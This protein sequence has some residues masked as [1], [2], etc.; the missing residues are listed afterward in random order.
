ME[1]AIVQELAKY[2]QFDQVIAIDGSEISLANCLKN[3][4]NP[5]VIGQVA[6]LGEYQT[7]VEILSDA[8]LA[9]ACLPHSLSLQTVKAAIE[10]KCHLVDLVGSQYEEKL[11]LHEEAKSAGVAIVPGCGVAPGIV[12]FLAA[13]GVELLD[14]A[15]EVTMICGGL[16]KN[17]IPPLWY[18][19][20]FRLE[21]VL[22]L[23]T[24]NAIAAEEGEIVVLPPFSKIETL[25]F[26]EPVGECE[27][28]ASDAHSVA[29]ILKDKVK[30]IYEKTVRYKGHFDK[31]KVLYELGFLDDKDVEVNGNIVN[32]KQ[33]AMTLL[34][35]NLKGTNKR[36]YYSV[37]SS[38]K[39]EKRTTKCRV[40]M[41]NGRFI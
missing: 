34:E 9:V 8:D 26:P 30:R 40:S 28:I 11:A 22:G 21:S 25:K 5:K 1:L 19:V 15:D 39:R 38:S 23:Y 18:Q 33:L 2:S 16:P 6:Q 12:S 36:R 10:A 13:K 35:P 29:Y 27:A 3:I 4:E 7:V 31:M 24:R 17:P 14:E 32:P 37:K 20:V 41:G